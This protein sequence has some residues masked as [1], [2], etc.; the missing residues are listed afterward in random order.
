MTAYRFFNMHKNKNN[1]IFLIL[2]A[3]ASLFLLAP[4][5]SAQGLQYTLLEKVP[6]TANV[7]SD[8]RGYI[9]AIY[10]IA[11]IIV[12]LSAVLMLSIGGFMYL[13]SAGNTSAMGTAKGVIFDSIIGLVI[14]L[15]AWLLLNVINPDLVSV[16]LNGLSPV[17]VGVPPVAPPPPA[18]IGAGCSGY[19]VSGISGSQCND[20][21]QGLAD[22]LSCMY[23]R[24]P[25]AKIT[26]ISDSA[27]FSTC[28]NGWNKPPCAHAQTSCHYGGGASRTESECQTSHAVDFSIKN[29]NGAID[30]AIAQAIMSASAACGGR[31]NDESGGPYPHI[32]ISDQTSCCSL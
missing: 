1:L 26:S 25:S 18:G 31:V 24:Y 28:K 9:E 23:N 16:T 19:S 2:L 4:D 3:C 7:G 6:G 17:A 20:T 5:A 14:A 11:L 15:A 30:L 22:I 27:G 8:L 12:T 10:K 21:S 13:T 29:A 32:H